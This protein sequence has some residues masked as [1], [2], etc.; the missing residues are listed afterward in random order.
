[1]FSWVKIKGMELSTQGACVRV[2]RGFVKSVICRFDF[3]VTDTRDLG[4]L[5]S[6]QR[7]PK[8]LCNEVVN[9][10]ICRSCCNRVTCSN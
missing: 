4:I 2:G 5:D 10:P 1:M 9:C 3:S 8:L 6:M 7:R